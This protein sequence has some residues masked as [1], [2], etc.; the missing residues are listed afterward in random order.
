[1]SKFKN[2]K[3]KIN[4]TQI[5]LFIF[6]LLIILLL[7]FLA[8]EFLTI[9]NFITNKVLLTNFISSNYILSVLIFFLSCIL[10]KTKDLFLA[11]LM[12]YYSESIES[13]NTE[14]FNNL[15]ELINI[16]EESNS[17]LLNFFNSALILLDQI[18]DIEYMNIS[19]VELIT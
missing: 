15:N 5:K 12:T 6:L 1:M 11:I 2:N 9:E 19:A 14:C 13:I 4:L 8:L 17:M 10:R 3:I 16:L 7:S 18:E